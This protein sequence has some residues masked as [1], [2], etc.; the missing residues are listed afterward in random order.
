M[1]RRS[2]TGED[3]SAAP[4]TSEDP[5]NGATP[6]TDID[7]EGSPPA[8]GEA[9]RKASVGSASASGGTVR[10]ASASKGSVGS[11]SASRDTVGPA[12]A[13]K[14]S[15]GSA[16][17]SRGTVGSASASKGSVGSA[18]ASRGTVGSASASKGSVGSA[19]ASR[20]TV[21]SA[22]AS[23]GSVGSASASRGTVGSASASRGSVGAASASR[24]TIG[25][26]SGSRGSV[27]ATTAS[28]GSVGA[29]SASRRSLGASTS[30]DT[31]GRMSASLGTIDEKRDPNAEDPVTGDDERRASINQDHDEATDAFS[32]TSEPSPDD[33]AAIDAHATPE[34]GDHEQG[35]DL[36]DSDLPSGDEDGEPQHSGEDSLGA[37]EGPLKPTEDGDTGPDEPG[38]V[39]SDAAGPVLPGGGVDSRTSRG[40]PG[41]ADA[42]AAAAA[43]GRDDK[44]YEAD[45]DTDA[46]PDSGPAPPASGAAPAIVIDGETGTGDDSQET[47]TSEAAGS[48]AEDQRE[49]KP[50]KDS[51]IVGNED[52]FTWLRRVSTQMDEMGITDALK[53]K[54]G[55]STAKVVYDNP[56]DVAPAEVPDITISESSIASAG[57]QT[58]AKRQSG[59]QTAAAQGWAENLGAARQ[60]PVQ[61]DGHDVIG[62]TD[63]RWRGGEPDWTGGAGR[64]EGGARGRGSDRDGRQFREGQRHGE[65]QQYWEGLGGAG[66]RDEHA[67]KDPWDGR[68]GQ[69]Y[70]DQR[71]DGGYRD[72]RGYRDDHGGGGP[73][74]GKGIDSYRDGRDRS[75]GRQERDRR[76][77]PDRDDDAAP[78]GRCRCC[79]AM[80]RA[81]SGAEETPEASSVSQQSEQEPE[82][83]P[84]PEP[85]PKQKQPKKRISYGD[86]LDDE[87]SSMTVSTGTFPSCEDEQRP[88]NSRQWLRG[89]ADEFMRTQ[90]LR[91]LVMKNDLVEP[92]RVR[93]KMTRVF[94]C[95]KPPLPPLECPQ[96]DAARGDRKRV[97]RADRGEDVGVCSPR[98]CS[99]R[100]R[101][102]PAVSPICLPTRLID[103][104]QLTCDPTRQFIDTY[105]DKSPRK[106]AGKRKGSAK[107][108]K[109]ITISTNV[110][111]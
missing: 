51:L 12:S 105:L 29:T 104:S 110:K 2:L 82:P 11:T 97:R 66:Y 47:E 54:Y 76:D 30:G 31:A 85:E 28:R 59:T 4:E 90:C 24:G 20:G 81:V 55:E 10:P 94:R 100:Y 107:T 14:G 56:A 9:E 37:D 89:V 48:D 72:D 92:G 36:A 62:G 17:A 19:S 21:G 27:G 88:R 33:G 35:S 8:E 7:G 60:P 6:A 41:S 111:A 80:R 57:Q 75:R 74:D 18:S 3:P 98:V 103:G 79:I 26:A 70:G 99:T 61:Y 78:C 108:K 87:L 50:I 63:P 43:V 64:D 86:L 23:R 67:G 5:S 46:S 106:K 91:Q 71:V 42:A 13:S 34:N 15:V 44:P 65:G 93:S 49:S 95:P 32:E 25:A 53:Q 73:R 16:S 40:A 58:P 96:L 84:G 83:E 109:L 101:K 1:G 39:S 52:V 69:D 68:G 38:P 102:P 22:S 45:T 77:G